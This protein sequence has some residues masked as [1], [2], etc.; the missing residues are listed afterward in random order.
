MG[1]KVT[2]AGT[3]PGGQLLARVAEGDEEALGLLYHEHA[4]SMLRLIR[5]LTANRAEAEEIL[6]EAWLA[7]WQSAAAFRGDSAPR[8]WL[9][10]VAR[11]QAHNRLRRASLSTTELDA[12]A[13]V[14]QSG[15]D[16][17]DRVLAGMEFEQVLARVRDLP[18]HL[19]EVLDLVLVEQL[20]YGEIA[21][22]LDVPVGTV[23]SRM[24]HIKRELARGTHWESAHRPP[25]EGSRR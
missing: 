24:S 12:A 20:S 6:Q 18:R 3:H 19:R 23:K 4:G 5:R 8:A 25:Q 2:E 10:G 11:R 16:V 7:V 1:N 9:L 14:P 15:P 22:V 21:G 13:Q 17:E